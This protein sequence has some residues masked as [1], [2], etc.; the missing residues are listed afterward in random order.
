ME[1]PLV[2]KDVGR[3]VQVFKGA[4]TLQTS[5]AIASPLVDAGL[6]DPMV[7]EAASAV[8]V[9]EP[10]PK[11]HTSNRQPKL[12][13]IGSGIPAAGSALGKDSAAA[14]GKS[15]EA[16]GFGSVDTGLMV[17]GSVSAGSTLGMDC[18]GL[19]GKLA[20]AVSHASAATYLSSG[21]R[22]G[23]G[24]YSGAKVLQQRVNSRLQ[25]SQG[26][27]Q[28]VHTGK[29]LHSKSS[30]SSGHGRNLPTTTAL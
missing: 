13:A 2:E 5:A 12:K 3:N 4:G 16:V 6:Q 9:W 10:V 1:S 30:L 23:L 21:L 27:G 8:H 25:P 29:S 28:R 20:E 11:K 19:K 7:Y 22:P 18:E 24:G 17:S 15:V 26:L 14:K